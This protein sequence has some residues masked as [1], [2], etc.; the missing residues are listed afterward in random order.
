[1]SWFAWTVPEMETGPA[2][3]PKAAVLLSH[4]TLF[5][6]SNQLGVVV[7]QVPVPPAPFV[8]QLSWADA[9]AVERRRRAIEWERM[10][11]IASNGVR[12]CLGGMHFR[13]LK[14]S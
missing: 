8:P 12:T 10:R 5:V 6:P 14:A 1:M 2:L 3:P 11:F 7:S 4:G 13:G 9:A